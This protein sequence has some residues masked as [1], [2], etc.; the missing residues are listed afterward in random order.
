MKLVVEFR[1]AQLQ[2]QCLQ[3]LPVAVHQGWEFKKQKIVWG[4]RE[5]MH[6]S[7]FYIC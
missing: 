7:P 1:S 4:E 2:N 6:E 5:R 3:A